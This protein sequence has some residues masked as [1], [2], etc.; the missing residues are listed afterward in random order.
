[1]PSTLPVC[2]SLVWGHA[3]SKLH[4]G[5]PSNWHFLKMWCPQQQK[6][7]FTK[8]AST[9]QKMQT[10]GWNA[11]QTGPLKSDEQGDG[12][13]KKPCTPFFW[14]FNFFCC[15]KNWRL[16]KCN[17]NPPYFFL[18]KM[19]PPNPHCPCPWP[20]KRVWHHLGSVNFATFLTAPRQMAGL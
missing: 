19:P 2:S 20:C 13:K 12:G 3:S 9:G 10:G 18:V 14:V 8:R 11:Q 15:R 5:M 7:H 1:M 17:R 4:A 16:Q 6:T